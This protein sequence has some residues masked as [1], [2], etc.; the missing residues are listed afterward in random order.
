FEFYGRK[1]DF[2]SSAC[3]CN[4]DPAAARSDADQVAGK[5]FFGSITWGGSGADY[6]PLA[7][8]DELAHK[9]VVSFNDRPLWV[10]ESSLAQRAPY[11]WSYLPGSDDMG[12]AA[13][14]EFMCKQLAH[15][16]ASHAASSSLTGT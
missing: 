8:Y 10:G 4:E 9:G 12:N 6:T 16:P 1:I 13:L 14:G 3:S 15:K 11:E 2:V 7:Y 5:G